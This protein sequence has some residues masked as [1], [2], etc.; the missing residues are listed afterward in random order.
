MNVEEVMTRNVQ[1]IEPDATLQEAARMMK[2]MDI[3]G[4]PVCDGEKLVGFI[5]DRDIC[6]GA[7]AEG[8]DPATCKVSDFMSPNIYTCF[9]DEDVTVAGRHMQERQIR[10]MMILDRSKKL[11]GILSLGDL[12]MESRIGEGYTGGV[13]GAVSEHTQ[14]MP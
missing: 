10:R 9:A 12:A 6:V 3:G 11:V 8:E 2:N 4:L 13:L 1:V 5:T 14:P 7:I